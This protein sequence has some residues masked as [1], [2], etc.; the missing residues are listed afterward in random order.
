MKNGLLVCFMAVLAGTIFINFVFAEDVAYIVSNP[1]NAVF[2]DILKDMNLSYVVIRNSEITP[3]YNFSGFKMLLI[4]DNYLSNW[5]RIPVNNM[6]AVVVNSYHV[7]NWGWAVKTSL[8][9]RTDGV[10]V[11]INISSELAEGLPANFKVYSLNP[12]DMY[13]LDKMDAYSGIENTAVNSFDN[14]DIAVGLIRAGTTLT[15]E[16]YPS[17]IVNANSVFFGLYDVEYWTNDTKKLFENVVLWIIEKESETSFELNLEEGINLVSL[18]I[19]IASNNIADIFDG[20]P[21]IISVKEYQNSSIVET[22]DMYNHRGYFVTSTS[23]VG[24]NLSGTRFSG[25]QTISLNQGMNLVGINSLNNISLSSL[26]NGIKEVSRR[27]SDGSY[28]IATKYI[29]G[30]HNPDNIILEPGKGYWVKANSQI[31]WS[32]TA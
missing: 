32:Y 3:G 27:N 17:T 7:A 10:Y 6:P 21:E 15:K 22:S 31:N 25:T 30:W 1:S 11:D 12:P 16:G 2:T 19:V 8:A 13:V 26:P 28:S 24:V 29:L 5:A 4:N 20:Y 14:K 23:N 18:P 9:S